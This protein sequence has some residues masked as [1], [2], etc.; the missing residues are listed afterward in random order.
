MS[1]DV[2]DFTGSVHVV[3]SDIIFDVNVINAV[4]DVNIQSATKLDINIASITTGVVFNVA[5]SGSW[6]VDANITNAVIDINIQS[7]AEGVVF[8]VNI[9]SAVTLNVAIQSSAVTLDVNIAAQS[10]DLNIGTFPFEKHAENAL[11]NP[12]FETGDLTGWDAGGWGSVAIDSTTKYSGNYSA[13]ITTP[14]NQPTT[15]RSTKL[16]PVHPGQTIQLVAVLKADANIKN[17]YLRAWF[18]NAEGKSFKELIS[19]DFGGNYDWTVKKFVCTVPDGAAYVR[20]VY[21]VVGG[22]EEGNAWIDCAFLARELKP[23]LD[24][25]L[26]LNINVAAQT[27]TLDINIAASAVTLDID[28]ET[29][30][31]VLNINNV[32][33]I[34]Q[35]VKSGSMIHESGYTDAGTTNDIYTVPSG[36]IFYLAGAL[37]SADI[38]GTGGHVGAYLRVILPGPVSRWLLVIGG[39]PDHNETVSLSPSTPLPYPAGTIFQLDGQA[40]DA[41]RLWGAV[42][43]TEVQSTE[44]VLDLA[45]NQRHY[46]YDMQIIKR[47]DKEFYNLL[48]KEGVKEGERWAPKDLTEKIDQ[49]LHEKRVKLGIYKE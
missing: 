23:A 28:I 49:E 29:Q 12:G 21:Y 18:Q 7:V 8:N 35:T 19:E 47:F 32:N 26:N 33:L 37:L 40:L 5:Q 39:D 34:D 38:D 31:A 4:L 3:G 6:T 42:F 27:A 41:G 15:I 25:D 10:V 44:A 14:A 1:T 48:R 16:V 11:E 22:S 46:A 43:G 24:T 13:K 36:Y 9:A 45:W 2:P 17:S 30:T 20:F